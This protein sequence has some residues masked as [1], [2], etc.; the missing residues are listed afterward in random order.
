MVSEILTRV[1]ITMFVVLH[2][3]ILCWHP[4]TMARSF[5]LLPLGLYSS[6]PKE[7]TSGRVGHEQ[8]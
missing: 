2:L 6:L 8:Q 3:L 5:S 4:G 1:T 7:R